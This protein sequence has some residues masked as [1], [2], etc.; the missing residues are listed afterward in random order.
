MYELT[1]GE[2]I[3]TYETRAEAIVAAKEISAEGHGLVAITDEQQ[4]ERP[5]YQGGELLS[6]DHDTRC[7]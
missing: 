6:Y 2:E 5:T 3:Q 4:R 7:R 1:F